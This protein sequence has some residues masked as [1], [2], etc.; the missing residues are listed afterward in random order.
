MQRSP[1]RFWR[2]ER[3]G[4]PSAATGGG[5]YTLH[6]HGPSSPDGA[7]R[8]RNHHGPSPPDRATPCDTHVPPRAMPD[9]FLPRAK[10]SIVGFGAA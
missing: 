1:Q 5:R 3:L 7:T 9:S 8:R 10:A 4:F 2:L 6:P